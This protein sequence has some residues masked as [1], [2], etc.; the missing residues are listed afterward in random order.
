MPSADQPR[1]SARPAAPRQGRPRREGPP[2]RGPS[3]GTRVISY[4]LSIGL[5]LAV[6][7]AMWGLPHAQLQDPEK[8]AKKEP[9]AIEV[10]FVPK[11]VQPVQAAPHSEV[12]QPQPEHAVQAPVEK[13]APPKPAQR[14]TRHVAPPK[15]QQH[16]TAHVAEKP[17]QEAVR[18]IRKPD[19]MAALQKRLAQ[20]HAQEESA[21][22]H[23]AS[24]PNEGT[25]QPAKEPAR[26]AAPAI[27][28]EGFSD[29]LAERGILVKIKPNYP[30]EDERAFHEGVCRLRVTVTPAGQVAE[31]FVVHSSGYPS[32][33]RAARA[34]L[35][36]WR[37]S[38][39]DTPG[40]QW[41]ETDFIFRI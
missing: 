20:S 9:I 37:F 4:E 40:N 28:S 5:H 32:L 18:P 39:V 30:E 7:L 10:A 16:E 25:D 12:H 33:D 26:H 19:P 22:S 17:V 23:I 29:G 13:P 27:N 34:A 38:P 1:P 15:V 31:V 6:F 41:G 8:V 21:L 36:R 24:N 14:T 3:R 2:R 11:P 35:Y